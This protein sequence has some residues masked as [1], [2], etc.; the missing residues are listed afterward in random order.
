MGGFLKHLRDSL[1]TGPNRIAASTALR[2]TI[3]T[4]APL[5]LLPRFGLAALAYPAVIGALGASMVDVGGPY[6]SRL[7]AMALLAVIGPGLMLLGARAVAAWWFAML[8]MFVIA[9]AAGL[10]RALGRGGIALGINVAVAF[11]VKLQIGEIGGPAA[12]WAAGYGGGALWTILV[13]L[14]FWQLRPYR[15]L[16]QEVAS[17]WEAVAGL[18]AATQPPAPEASV[19]ARRRREQR[20]AASHRAAREAVEQ[21]RDALGE[22][23]AGTVGPGTTVAQ[24][25]VLLNAAARIG[26]AAVA[27]GE[28]EPAGDP[29]R[30][31][32]GAELERQCRAVARI[33]L[34]GRGGLSL[35][36]LR[37]QLQQ[38]AAHRPAESGPELLAFA[39]A[40]RHLDNAEEAIAALFG[41]RHRLPHLL[42]LPFAHRRPPG[43]VIAALR[44]H[45]T[46]RSAIFRHAMRVAVIAAIGTAAI[47]RFRLPHG[48][49]LPLTS[50][51]I[52]QPDYGGTLARALQR[53]GGTMA[54]AVV[55]G[56]LLA[57]V[58]GT[59]AYDAAIGVLLFATFFLIRR[60]YGLAIT[61][62]TPLII[63]LIGAG[64]ADP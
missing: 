18:V 16:E 28:I 5:V 1:A 47:V 7:A 15:R 9:A 56:I 62:L 35:A 4:V 46:P 58:R 39:Q 36:P 48:I 14:A 44:A 33:L 43:T 38:W 51:V 63:L 49:W 54:G 34:N 19:I 21:G 13:A 24:L 61:F 12:V 32:A 2:G 64:S 6:R 45:L 31:A 22:M 25:V 8:V 26:A 59:A 52:L 57:S 42:R 11:L 37:R 30:Q 55:A 29:E 40:M 20:I 23:R 3:A 41:Q 60:R 10:V 17:A 53:A 50:L 27:L